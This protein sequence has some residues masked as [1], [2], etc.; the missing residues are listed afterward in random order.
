MFSLEALP[1]LV[2]PALL[3]TAALRDLVS[4]TIPNWISGALLLAFPVAALITGLGWGEVAQHAAVG[5]VA[6][7][8]GMGLFAMNW[9]GGGDAKLLSASALWL[10]LAA[11]PEY[12]LWTALA[13]GAL[14][15]ILVLARKGSAVLPLSGAPGWTQ[16]LLNPKGDVPYGVALAVG[17]LLAFPHSTL[18]QAAL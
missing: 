16:A 11:A 17:G 1:V 13:G 10:G 6:L 4:F 8:L 5:G 15:I 3:V 7:V 9:V 14:S 18:F 12:L 2:F